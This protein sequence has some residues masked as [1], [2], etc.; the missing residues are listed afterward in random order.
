MKHIP[1]FLL[2]VLSIEVIS[3]GLTAPDYNKFILTPPPPVQPRITGPSVYG[4][5]PGSP[6]LYR[7]PCTGERPLHFY[8]KGLPDGMTSDEKTL[9]LLFSIK[10]GIL[11]PPG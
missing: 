10:Y 3:Q 2:I 7:I 11:L 6:F 4:V 1:F 9:P 5:R 8:V